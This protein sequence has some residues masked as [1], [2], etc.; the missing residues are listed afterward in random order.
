M[1][2]IASIIQA[3]DSAQSRLMRRRVEVEDF[4]KHRKVPQPL[5]SKVSD[6]CNYTLERKVIKEEADIL[7]GLS[8]SL[9]TQVI[10][11][12]YKEV[13]EKVPL[14]K[15]KPPHFITTLVTCL[16]L[17]YYA[18]GDIVMRQGEVGREMYFIGEAGEREDDCGNKKCGLSFRVYTK[19][20]GATRKIEPPLTSSQSRSRFE[21]K[22]SQGIKSFGK[23][24]LS[25][26]VSKLVRESFNRFGSKSKAVASDS[27]TKTMYLVEDELENDKL[28]FLEVDRL[29]TGGSFGVYSCILGEPS[30]ATVIARCFCELH[31]LRRCDLEEVLKQWPELAGELS[32]MLQDQS[33]HTVED[34][35]WLLRDEMRL[36]GRSTVD[37]SHQSEQVL[38][39]T[40]RPSPK[41]SHQVFPRSRTSPRDGS[42]T[43]ATL[44]SAAIGQGRGVASTRD[45]A[46]QAVDS[47]NKLSIKTQ[48]PEGGQ[49]ASFLSR[50][51]SGHQEASSS[52]G[53]TQLQMLI[54][55]TAGAAR[56]NL[57][58]EPAPPASAP[59]ASQSKSI[60]WALDEAPGSEAEL[61]PR[62]GLPSSMKQRLHGMSKPDDQRPLSLA[63][64]LPPGSNA[65]SPSNSD[66]FTVLSS[67]IDG[68][69]GISLNAWESKGLV[70]ALKGEMLR[71]DSLPKE[72]S[73]SRLQVSNSG[74]SINQEQQ[75]QSEL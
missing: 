74:R 45:A 22:T 60:K 71:N 31:S 39:T 9:K 68:G 66:A 27:D 40:S 38:Q 35:A 6:F 59:S 52:P 15:D 67:S 65:D 14:F 1:A 53:L 5:S 42:T 72:L 56:A 36:P 29:Y 50:L 4:L 21:S 19:D 7:A 18:K 49:Q 75:A 13:L 11:H 70:S 55:T 32:C 26:N 34:K 23:T 54:T 46:R 63:D 47:T 20:F 64:G 57:S 12:L 3:S 51:S 61:P 2:S 8:M 41:P 30:A 17:E 44:S 62:P 58:I 25:L 24:S 10:M 28:D 16:K 33:Y 48:V 43:L 37:A 73:R 69:R